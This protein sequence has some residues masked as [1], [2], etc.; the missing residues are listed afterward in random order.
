M[1]RIDSRRDFVDDECLLGSCWALGV[2]YSGVAGSYTP[3]DAAAHAKERIQ[4]S[5]L[6]METL[7]ALVKPPTNKVCAVRS[8]GDPRLRPVCVVSTGMTAA[9]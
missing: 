9:F 2:L 7:D 8:S 4:T 5:Y 6:D 1:R 3:R